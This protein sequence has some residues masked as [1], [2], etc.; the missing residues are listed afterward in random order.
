MGAYKVMVTIE[1]R[2]GISDPEGETILKDLVLME[3][4][5]PVTEIRCSKGLRF[6]LSADGP[7][8]ATEEVRRICDDLR[9]Y[10]PLV[11]RITVSIQ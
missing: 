8:E 11:S 7:G 3:G 2:Q 5:S 9:I 4:N 1:N 6:T 10:N